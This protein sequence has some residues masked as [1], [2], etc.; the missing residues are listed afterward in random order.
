MDALAPVALFGRNPGLADHVCCS[1]CDGY[2]HL[3]E[4]DQ[5]DFESTMALWRVT[6]GGVEFITDRYLIVRADLVDIEHK[7][8]NLAEGDVQ[9]LHDAAFHEPPAEKPG[10]SS[11]L[12]QAR[13]VDLLDKVGITIADGG[14]PHQ[15]QPLYRGDEHVGWLMPVRADKKHLSSGIRVGDLLSVRAILDAF[16]ADGYPGWAATGSINDAAYVLNL[17]RWV[18]DIVAAAPSSSNRP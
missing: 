9:T 18:P 15:A 6:S 11:A 4:L 7:H 1:C 14:D 16:A 2:C 8:T 12:F 3:G 13:Y 5:E 17:S 10:V